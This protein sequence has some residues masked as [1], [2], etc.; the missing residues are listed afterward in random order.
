MLVVQTRDARVFKEAEI[1][2]LSEAA[3]A[4]RSGGE[5]G[6]N[7]GPLCGSFA[8]AAVVA[9]AQFLVELG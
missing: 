3:D 7:A 2:M 5:R 4:T 6:A 1:K 8:G 9:G